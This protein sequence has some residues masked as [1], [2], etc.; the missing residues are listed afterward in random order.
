M[1]KQFE[2]KENLIMYLEFLRDAEAVKPE[3]EVDNDLIDACVY[4]LLDLQNKKV[5][6]TP[7]QIKERVRNIPFK[8][9]DAFEEYKNKKNKTIRTKRVLI[10]AACIAVLIALLSFISSATEYDI[11]NR[12]FASFTDMPF[13]TEYSVDN[14]SFVKNGD[15]VFYKSFDKAEKGEGINILEPKYIPDNS[16]ISELNFYDLDNQRTGNIIFENSNVSFTVTINGVVIDEIKSNI[17]PE[18]I[19]DFECYF[20]IMD[21]INLVQVYFEHDGNLYRITY[22]SKDEL[23]KMIESLKE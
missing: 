5:T 10:I 1:E 18:I 7:E 13:D 21:D 15:S 4:V 20:V 6:L 14:E 9:S 8:D 2:N 17:Q 19:N 11:I 3:N 12:F 22:N 23:V 16:E